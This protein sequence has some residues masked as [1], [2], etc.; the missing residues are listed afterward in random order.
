MDNFVTHVQKTRKE[1]IDV[2]LDIN[3]LKNNS[4]VA[5]KVLNMSSSGMC[6]KAPGYLKPSDN[7]KLQ[8][9]LTNTGEK[10]TVNTEVVWCEPTSPK[11]KALLNPK[12]KK[13][14]KKKTKKKG[15]KKKKTVKRKNLIPDNIECKTGLKFLG[16]SLEK[17]GVINDFI[18]KRKDDLIRQKIGLVNIPKE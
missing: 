11:Y 5:A 8:I 3:Y 9:P 6:F 14:T 16:L 2:R 4:S 17:N 18:N 7:I 15:P 13:T 10:I 1:R 12:S